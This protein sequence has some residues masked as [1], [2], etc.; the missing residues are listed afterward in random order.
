MVSERLDLP[1]MRSEMRMEVEAGL[2]RVQ[3]VSFIAA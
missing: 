3:H 1:E 2:H